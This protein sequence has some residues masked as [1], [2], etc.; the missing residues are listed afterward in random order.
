MRKT[1]MMANSL[2]Y[3]LRYP[4]EYHAGTINQTVTYHYPTAEDIGQILN[5]N[6]CR[7]FGGGNVYNDA[8]GFLD[9]NPHNT[10]HLW[11]G[12]MNPDYVADPVGPSPVAST[13]MPESNRN[14][15]V[16]VAGRRFHTRDD[17]YSQP[18]FGDMFSNLTASYDP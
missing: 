11:T 1:L 3:P 17:L 6:N 18:K 15:G 2:G 10:M 14:R 7:D 12:G 4:A 16:Q 9:Q 5:L 13:T 8:F